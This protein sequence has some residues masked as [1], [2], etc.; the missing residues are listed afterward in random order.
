M[1][2]VAVIQARM[3]SQRLP[4]KVMQEVAGQPVLALLISRVQRAKS[5]D[6][7]WLAC[8]D[9][10][11]DEPIAELGRKAG[12]KVFRGDEEDVLSRFV[13]I[14]QRTG[15]D[16]VVR[17]TGDC[18]FAD[19]SIIDN[20]V[21]CY[22]EGD[23][24]FVSNTLQRS[25]PDGLDVEVIA[26]SALER[27]DREACLPFLRSH[28]TPYIHGRLRDKL[29]WGGF[30]I[31]QVTN[32]VDFSYL[33]WTLDE[34]DDLEFFRRI[35]PLLP[36]HFTW[37]DVIEVLAREPDLAQINQGHRPYEGSDRDLAEKHH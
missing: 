17:I 30:R 4:G 31:S 25:Y 23:A 19:P 34:A 26:R 6:E 33:R 15:A 13:I 36:E 3:R 24:D 29:P 1:K 14:A 10:A 20:I 8:S 37:R 11:D 12:I 2:I 21:A 27:A 22:K 18:P 35:T 16:A 5:V 32:D 9:V 7:I 28:V